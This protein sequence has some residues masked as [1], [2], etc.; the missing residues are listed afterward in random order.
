[1]GKASKLAKAKKMT[2][3]LTKTNTKSSH[4]VRTKLRF[5][6]PKTR[7]TKSV[8]TTLQSFK[9]EIRRKNNTGVDYTTVLIQPVSS[10]KNMTKMENEN[11]I[12]FVVGA[13]SKKSQIKEAFEKLYGTQVRTVRTLNCIGKRK[14][15]YIRLYNDGDA[16][17]VA[18]KIGIL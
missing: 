4:R 6:R 2:N 9:S 16:L 17:N 14:K 3:Q 11:T 8:S 18:S 12:T 1:M 5:Y 15:A 10:D 13:N 7:M